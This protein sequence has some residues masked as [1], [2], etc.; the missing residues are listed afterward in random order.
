[1]THGEVMKMTKEMQERLDSIRSASAQACMQPLRDWEGE[2]GDCISRSGSVAWAGPEK[3]WKF[4]NPS[5]VRIPDINPLNSVSQ[6]LEAIRCICVWFRQLPIARKHQGLEIIHSAI[7]T[8]LG[9]LRAVEVRL[10][11]CC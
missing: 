7:R 10:A 3:A 9:N 8:V 4:S 5:F 11:T 1:M 2:W 6:R